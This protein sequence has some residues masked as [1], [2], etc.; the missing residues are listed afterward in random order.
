MNRKS[1]EIIY[2]PCGAHSGVIRTS[3]TKRVTHMTTAIITR[4]YKLNMDHP[5]YEAGKT[6]DEKLAEWLAVARI[7]PDTAFHCLE[8]CGV[9]GVIDEEA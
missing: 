9:E 2:Y 5:L 6:D 3:T 7:D 1:I 4:T 8:Q